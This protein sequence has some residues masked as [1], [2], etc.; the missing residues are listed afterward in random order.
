MAS[1]DL[2]HPLASMVGWENPWQLGEIRTTSLDEA[3][4]FLMVCL[5]DDHGGP[6]EGD[7]IPSS[8]P[9]VFPLGDW[10][11]EKP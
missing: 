10:Y 7:P 9:R 3:I 1:W 2:D 4:W 5:L 6:T 8:Y 11:R